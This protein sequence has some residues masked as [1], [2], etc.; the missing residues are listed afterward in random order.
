M[1]DHH[2][3]TP[4][5]DAAP[6][7]VDFWEQRYLDS[8]RI[9]SGRVNATFAALA[10]PLTP[11]RALDLGCGEGADVVWLAQQGWDATGVDISATAV[12]RATRAAQQVGATGARFVAADLDDLAALPD[13]GPFDLVTASF[14]HSPVALARTR[15][16]RAA[17]ALVADGGHLLLVTHAAAP[18]WA[19]LPEHTEHRF[20]TPVEEVE[21][22]ALEPQQWETVVVEIRRREVS[23]PSGD[24]AV[25]DDGAILLRRRPTA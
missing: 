10:S 9:W 8:D 23:S 1:S 20:L 6:A 24:P 15:I 4:D 7:P 25:L 12:D 2:A 16:L 11:G 21:E 18:P 13:R 5:A 3:P 22:L 17:A 14:L 19:D